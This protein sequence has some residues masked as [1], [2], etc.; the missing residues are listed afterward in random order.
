[1]RI[2]QLV[3]APKAILKDRSP[4]C[5]CRNIYRR[6]GPG[7]GV[8]VTAALLTE[9]GM[10][11]SPRKGIPWFFGTAWTKDGAKNLQAFSHNKRLA[12]KPVPCYEYNSSRG[13]PALY[14]L[15]EEKNGS[16]M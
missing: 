1:M 2:G 13:S 12:E 7:P 11:F 6:E 15:M 5:G 16:G 10:F 3:K 14:F 8:G 4:S 9:N